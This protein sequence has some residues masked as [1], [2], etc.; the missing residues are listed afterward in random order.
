MPHA[1]LSVHNLSKIYPSNGKD[2]CALNNLTFS[3]HAGEILGLLGP[4]GA[5]KTTTVSI[6][7]GTLTQSNGTIMY[8]GKPFPQQRSAILQKVGFASSYVPFPSLLSI[9]ESLITHG[10]LQGMQRKT[11]D[12][13]IT[14]FLDMFSLTEKRHHLFGSLSAGQ[15]TRVL[16]IKAFLHEP[17]IVILDEPTAALDPDV[18]EQVRGFIMQER[19]KRNFSLFFTSH[20][21]Y[22][23][24]TLCDRVLVLRNGKLIASDSPE[25]LVATISMAHLHFIAPEPERLAA[26]AREHSIPFTMDEKKVSFSISE[27][28]V[29]QVLNGVALQNIPYSNISIDKPTLEDYFFK[30]AAHER[31]S[32]KS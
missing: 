23:I 31:R 5:G 12:Q 26:F 3:L 6:L 19:K 24:S 18:A 32:E 17:D 21:M 20:N 28:D 16:L 13:K 30:I 14:Y 29:A 15:R 25:K 1:V 27:H 2:F 4:N 8:F 11:I 10:R 7:L 9:E 22:E